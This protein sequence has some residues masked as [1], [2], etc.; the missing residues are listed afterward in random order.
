MQRKSIILYEEWIF[1]ILYWLICFYLYFIIAWWGTSDYFSQGPITNYLNSP[2][3]H[4]EIVAQALLM[5]VLFNLVNWFTS[6]AGFHKRSLGYI[7]LIKSLLYISAVG[8]A[9]VTVYFLFIMLDIK[10]IQQPGLME[11]TLNVKFFASLAIYMV[12]TI[13]LMNF[14]LQINKKFGHGNLLKMMAGRYHKPRDEQRIFMFL[15]M[16]SS[17]TIAEKVGH[18]KYSQLLQNCFHDL[19]DIVIKYRA[20]I[21]QFV[22]DEV[23]LSWTLKKGI[24]TLNCIKTFFAFEKKLNSEKEDYLKKFQFFPEFRAGMDMGTVTVTEIG[25]IKRELAFHGDVLN[26]ASRIQGQCKVQKRKLLISQNLMEVLPDL[27]EFASEFIGEVKLRGKNNSTNIYSINFR[28]QTTT[29]K[30]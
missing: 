20:D 18:F 30:T 5:G 24:K 19:T 12:L 22:G 1:V 11:D 27:N 2:F 7:I 8:V 25:D 29:D 17:T 28:Q 6:K 26:T 14:L 9:G 3:V 13:V 4:L 10:I 21:Y 16:K 15:D 23:V